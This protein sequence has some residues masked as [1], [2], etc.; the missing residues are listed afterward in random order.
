MRGSYKSKLPAFSPSRNSVVVSNDQRYNRS[1]KSTG[2]PEEGI[3]ESS[4]SVQ[5]SK[6]AK[7]RSLSLENIG[8]IMLR[9]SCQSCPSTPKM[10]S[11]RNGC[12]SLCHMGP[13]P[14]LEKFIAR[15]AL[16]CS[17]SRVMRTLLAPVR[18]NS[19]NVLFPGGK[20]S[21]WPVHQSTSL[22]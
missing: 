9:L 7:L 11:P 4:L 2:P 8:L 21:S 17:G 13:W 5:V 16:I 1:F 19:A 15:I 18:L 14:K 22:L 3:L 10:P 12:H 20:L 6:M